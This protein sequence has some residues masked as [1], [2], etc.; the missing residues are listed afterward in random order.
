MSNS[1]LRAGPTVLNVFEFWDYFNHLLSVD[2]NVFVEELLYTVG[3]EIQEDGYLL[4]FL[5]VSRLIYMHNIWK[6]LR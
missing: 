6:N 1:V 3:T 4:E 2:G 5:R